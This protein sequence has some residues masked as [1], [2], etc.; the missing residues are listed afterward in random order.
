MQFPMKTLNDSGK[1]RAAIVPG[2]TGVWLSRMQHYCDL[3]VPSASA[4]VYYAT[5]RVAACCAVAYLVGR[6]CKSNGLWSNNSTLYD[7]APPC[8]DVSR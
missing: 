2:V 6:A 5:L 3:M 4:V 7:A 8:N 1:W